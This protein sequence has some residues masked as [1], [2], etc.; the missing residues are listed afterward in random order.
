MDELIQGILSLARLSYQSFTLVPLDL[1][2]AC[3]GVVASK[4]SEILAAGAVVEIQAEPIRALGH[5]SLLTLGL[6][7]LLANALKFTTPDTPPRIVIRVQ[8][9]GQAARISV[10]D[11]G[12]GILPAYH[13]RVF[14]VFERLHPP[15]R[16]PGIGIGLALVRR[17]AE[18][19]GGSVGVEANSEGGATFWIELGVAVATQEMPRLL[20]AG[21]PGLSG[22]P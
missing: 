8:S 4:Q 7:H 2:E 5:P 21:S 16:F 22:A 10:S 20:P 13:Q 15:E 17:A 14:G 18:R 19:M 11:N 9:Q 1:S 6:D 3:R 12:I